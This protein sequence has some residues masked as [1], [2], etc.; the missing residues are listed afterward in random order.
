M[1]T[2]MTSAP[3]VFIVDDEPVICAS[4]SLLLETIN[5]ETQAFH[6]AEDFLNHY[7][8]EQPGCLLLD[9]NLPRMNGSELHARLQDHHISLPVIVMTAHATVVLAV[10]FMKKSGVIDFLEKPID[11]QKLFD[12]VNKAIHIDRVFR[13]KQEERRAAL[14]DFACLTQKERE[15]LDLLVQGKHSKEIAID[16]GISFRTVE[17]H[18]IKVMQKM[19]VDN[20]PTLVQKAMLCGV[21]HNAF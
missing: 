11:T 12:T 18:R 2:S 1:V 13:Q 14:E 8:V 9:I 7:Q 15:V 3:T 21:F 10:D 20:L 5:L 6:T 4:L 19:Q 16:M 17:K